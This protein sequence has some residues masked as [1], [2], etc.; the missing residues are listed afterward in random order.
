MTTAEE[1]RKMAEKL[2]TILYPLDWTEEEAHTLDYAI[3]ALREA[4]EMMRDLE[5]LRETIAVQDRIIA[6]AIARDL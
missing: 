3:I 1:Y 6:A 2:E 4:A 5:T